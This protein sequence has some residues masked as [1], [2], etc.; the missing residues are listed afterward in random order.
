MI[1]MMSRLD[2]CSE[3]YAKNQLFIFACDMAGTSQD[4]FAGLIV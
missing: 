2:F 4:N 1:G 3:L